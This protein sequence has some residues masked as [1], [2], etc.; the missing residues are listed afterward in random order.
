MRRKDFNKLTENIVSIISKEITELSIS[1][2]AAVLAHVS[3]TLL[4]CCT[5]NLDEIEALDKDK[6]I[7]I[8]NKVIS[9]IRLQIIPILSPM[10]IE[11]IEEE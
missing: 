5:D 1:D 6:L 10:P 11:T 8:Y 7:S 3:A 9:S 2:Q 4:I